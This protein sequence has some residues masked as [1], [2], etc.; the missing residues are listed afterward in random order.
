VEA[1][2]ETEG[3]GAERGGDSGSGPIT[4]LAIVKGGPTA[5]PAGCGVARAT[6]KGGGV[7]ATRN[8]VADRW[9]GT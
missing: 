8:G 6:V 9:V 7:G 4:T 5:A 3:G 1:E 2:R